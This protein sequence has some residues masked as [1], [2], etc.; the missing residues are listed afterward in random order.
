MPGL[1]TLRLLKIWNLIQEGD[2]YV[3]KNAAYGEYSYAAADDMAFNES[4]RSLFTW[5]KFD[6]LG[7]EGCWKIETV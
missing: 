3:I 6:N 1:V 7:P 5:K 2:K 4:S